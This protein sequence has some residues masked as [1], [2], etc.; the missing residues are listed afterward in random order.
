MVRYIRL[1]ANKDAV[2]KKIDEYSRE[3]LKNNDGWWLPAK[4]RTRAVINE[5]NY[6]F[7]RGYVL[8][9]LADTLPEKSKVMDLGGGV[10]IYSKILSDMRPDLEIVSFDISSVLQ[11]HGEK[12]FGNH[13]I[14]F[15]NGDAEALNSFSE[16]EFDAI[17]SLEA[18]EHFP[19][20]EAVL[21]NIYVWGKVNCQFYITTPNYSSK[22]SDLP[23]WIKIFTQNQYEKTEDLIYDKAVD[24]EKI[25]NELNEIGAEYVDI[26][27]TQIMNEWPAQVFAKL[28][29]L[30][31]SV[32]FFCLVEQIPLFRKQL[33]FTQIINFTKEK[34]H[35]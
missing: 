8:S 20:W 4:K 11:E 18:L 13:Q 22:L 10:G 35:R 23:S 2:K 3:R 34:L 26:K 15:V 30:K 19:A 14:H 1:D 25:V 32:W 12:E 17:F 6:K 27:Y 28:F 16:H 29:G 9:K 7:S 31:M 24:T 21:A 33:G 5:L